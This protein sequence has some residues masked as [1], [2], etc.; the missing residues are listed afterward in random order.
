MIARSVTTAPVVWVIACVLCPSVA[1]AQAWAAGDVG[2]SITRSIEPRAALAFSA[3]RVTGLLDGAEMPGSSGAERWGT[4]H[5]RLAVAS[6]SRLMLETGLEGAGFLAASEPD[7]GY[8]A[9]TLRIGLAN[10]TTQGWFRISAGRLSDSIGGR[11]LLLT[12]LDASV[13]RGRVSLSIALTEAFAPAQARTIFLPAA[14]PTLDTVGVPPGAPTTVEETL[15]SLSWQEVRAQVAWSGGRIGAR[16]IGGLSIGR[17]GPPSTS[18]LR[19]EATGAVAPDV[20]LVAGLGRQPLP[21]LELQPPVGPFTFG[22]RATF[23]RASPRQAGLPIEGRRDPAF[24]LRS[25]AGESRLL[26]FRVPHAKRVEL[27]GDFLD[28]RVVQ[29]RRQGGMWEVELIIAPGSYRL[30]IRIDGG[31]WV[32]PPGLPAVGD[33]FN[34]AAGL[35]RVD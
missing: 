15:R 35:L 2:T 1:S 22:I 11:P 13:T 8:A 12:G 18:W 34:A 14:G 19:A 33:D 20:A 26:R 24:E 28:W 23:G 7:A 9:G 30:N 10:G 4:G 27:T 29:L 3:W 16:L 31:P 25:V 21:I 6:G 5:V 17:S 32:V